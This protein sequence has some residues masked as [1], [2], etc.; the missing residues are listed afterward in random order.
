MFSEK[1]MLDR[2]QK[3]WGVKHIEHGSSVFRVK[4]EMYL[5]F[6]AGPWVGVSKKCEKSYISFNDPE[7]MFEPVLQKIRNSMPDEPFQNVVIQLEVA[8][9]TKPQPYN[10]FHIEYDLK[11]IVGVETLDIDPDNFYQKYV[12]AHR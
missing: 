4:Y 6:D 9:A 12:V 8:G 5:S 3:C 11:K 10:E 2:L 1:E 7:N